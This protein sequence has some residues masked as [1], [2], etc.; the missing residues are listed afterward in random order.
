MAEVSVDKVA[1]YAGQDADYT[2]RLYEKLFGEIEKKG[3]HSVFYEIEMPLISV[4]VEM[5]RTGIL[6]DTGHLT[7]LRKK[8][9]MLLERTE[10]KIYSL[11]GV[12][13]NIASPKQLK[14]VLFD[15]MKIQTKGLKKTK[16]GLST[17][18]SELE[19]LRG[20]HPVVDHIFAHRELAKLQST[21]IDALPLL[22]NKD[23]GRIH[24]SF[25]QVIA[26]TGRLSS[27]EPNMQNIPI[28]TELGREIRRAFIAADGFCL[29]SLDYSQIELRVAAHFSQDEEMIQAFEEDRDIH[30]WTAA[31]VFGKD[32]HGVT[33]EERRRAKEANFGVLY[34]LG[35]RGLAERL[36]IAYQEAEDFIER[37]RALYPKVFLFLQSVVETARKR[38]YAETLYGRR[39]Y[40][41]DINSGSPMLKAA[42]ERAALNMPFQGTAA[43]IMKLAMIK[44][45][46]KFKA[47]SSKLQRKTENWQI[48]N[49]EEIRMLL[50]VHDELVFEVREDAILKWAGTI[51]EEMEGAVHLRA[52]LK[53]DAKV[54][55]NWGEMNSVIFSKSF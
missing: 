10:Q 39:R 23:T 44:V 46:S 11:T 32:E 5:E 13:F 25:N 16:T 15:K 6:I 36:D 27:S 43:D 55:K 26:A 18:A 3:L 48:Q 40:L 2:W 35:P 24:T 42:A 4:L 37:Y 28:R 47:Q 33:P 34:G 50:Q 9:E 1:P 22:I 49:S 30:T 8:V 21:Y 41:P 53:V 20:A 54:G 52:P 29:L 7:A 12:T 19:K 14:D 31:K 17:A 38:G 45:S 51:R